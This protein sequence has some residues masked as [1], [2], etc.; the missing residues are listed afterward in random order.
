MRSGGIPILTCYINV[1]SGLNHNAEALQKLL[2]LSGKGLPSIYI[3]STTAGTN[4]PITP[5]GA[6][7]LDNAGVLLGLVLSQLNQ[8]RRA[9]HHARYAARPHGYAHDEL[10]L[11]LSGARHFPVAGANV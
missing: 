10:T 6:V 7:A 2:Y 3:P 4:S 5:A 11:C 9:I 8:R 1:V